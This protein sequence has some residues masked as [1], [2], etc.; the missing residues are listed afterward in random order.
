MS[1][2]I[3]ITG[4]IGSGKSVVSNILRAH[5]YTVY[6]CDSEAKRLMNI[7]ADIHD[8]LNRL[9]HPK[10]VENHTINRALIADVVFAS[11]D[12]L[13]TLNSIVHRAVLDDIRRIDVD[14]LVRHTLFIETA[15]LYQSHIDEMV[16]SVWNVTAPLEVRIERVIRR[17]NCT[18]EQVVSR[19]NSQD[20]FVPDV[21][22]PA[23][24]PIVNDGI[25]PLIPQ[26]HRLLETTAS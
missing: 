15:I 20:C 7:D 6:D 9:I 18:R 1:T 16:D 12:K 8:K 2:I 13:K 11:A 26:L 24:Y 14:K 17:N 3:A 25:T 5:S 21:P 22:H 23:V 10:A 4:G 19:I